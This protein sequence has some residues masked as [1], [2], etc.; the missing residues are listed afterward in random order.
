MW[1]DTTAYSKYDTARVPSC[2]S[3]ETGKMTITVL[4]NHRNYPG[5]W[6]MHCFNVGINNGVLK[7]AADAT[8]EDAQQMA[9]SAVR[10]R[11]NAMLKSLP[12]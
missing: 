6:V 9:V 5:K 10:A 11:L 1:E 4:N 2:W 8:P 7:I 3:M 12:E